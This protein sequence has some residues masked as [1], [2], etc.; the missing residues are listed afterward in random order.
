M[1]D[2]TLKCKEGEGEDE[3]T[4]NEENPPLHYVSDIMIIEESMMT[5]HL[6]EIYIIQSMCLS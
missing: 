3:F 4:F 2:V 5:M 1:F 6:L